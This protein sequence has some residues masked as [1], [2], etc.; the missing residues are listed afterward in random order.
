LP[1]ASGSV[2]G[3]CRH[4][5]KDRMERAGMRWSLEGAEALVQMR[6]VYLSDDFS[7]YWQFHQQQE[8]RRAYPPGAY[9]VVVN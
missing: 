4:L 3:A 5:V 8:Q 2:E 6:A 9:E 1:I 7:A